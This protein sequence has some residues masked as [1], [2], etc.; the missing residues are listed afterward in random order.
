MKQ[1]AQG[2]KF[3]HSVNV[4]HRDIKPANILYDFDG[5]WKI[6]DLG[7]ARLL[8][9]SMTPRTGTPLY[10]APEQMQKHYDSRVD[11]FAF[12]LII[13][14]ICYP[15]R[16]FEHHRDC[17]KGLRKS[18]IRFPKVTDRLSTFPNEMVDLIQGMLK[19]KPEERTSIQT[20]ITLLDN[21]F[22]E[23]I[24][25]VVQANVNPVPLDDQN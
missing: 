7:L 12:G 8:D 18:E 9:T 3:L 21:L 23:V 22:P 15:I 25:E 19:R 14:E 1:V 5:N 24:E 6:S 4:V 2:L 20:V 13:F 17:F 10:F 16:N 11:V